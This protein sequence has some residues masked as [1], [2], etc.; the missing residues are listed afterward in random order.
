[1]QQGN[2]DHDI[3][4]RAAKGEKTDR[5]PVWLMRQAGR[6]MKDFRAYSDKYPF[7]KRSEDPSIAVELSMQPF[8]AFGTDGVIMFSDILTPLPS[9][10]IDFD[11]IK[12]TGPVIFDPV[13]SM[14]TVKKLTPIDDPDRTTPFI[15]KIL[16]DL[17]S[18]TEG[19]ATLLGFIG[20][21]FTLAAYSVEGKANK[22][23]LETKKMMYNNPEIM[24]AFLNHISENI[25]AYACHQIECGAQV[26]QVFESW[27]HHLGPEDFSIFAKPYA[28]RAIELIKAKHPDTPI[29]YFANGGS[30]YLERQK[31]MKSDMLCVDWGVDMAEARKIL[32]DVPVSGN[33]DPL[34]LMGPEE[35][36]R[37]AVRDCVSKTGGHSHILNLGHGVIQQTPE[38]AVAAFVDEAKKFHYSDIKS[39]DKKTLQTV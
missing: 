1:M 25:A 2:E 8:N 26:L 16:G 36:I 31:D 20:S 15:R 38:E 32:G 27:A 28:D 24:H 3:L 17:R 21:P 33:V 11:V 29:I 22:N 19:K 30:S 6:Y 34:V 35:G 18:E 7:R 14:D 39:A 37:Q 12:G 9:M 10:G 4:L 23:C 13:R 5:S